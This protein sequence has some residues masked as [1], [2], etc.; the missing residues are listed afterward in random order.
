MVVT[1]NTMSSSTTD[2]TELK[3]VSFN[4]HGFHQGCPTIEDLIVNEKPDIFLL[5]EHWLTP[6]NL[7]CF[8]NWFTDYVA[9]GCSAM[10]NCV[11]KGML[12]GRPFSGVMSLVNKSLLSHTQVIHYEKRFCI[13]KVFNY[14]LINVYLPCAGLANRQTV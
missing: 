12:R 2:L 9:F 10:S 11:E 6:A 14:I 7:C 1:N 8:E 3:L 5:Q 4:M 13:I